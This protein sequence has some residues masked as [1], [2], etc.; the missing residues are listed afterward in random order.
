VSDDRSSGASARGRFIAFEGGEG[1]GK[2]TQ[3]ARLARSLDALLTREPGGTAVGSQLRDL[4]LDPGTVGLVAR[5][6][7]LLMAADRAQ[8]VEQVVGPALAAGRHVVT[9]RFAGSSV[10]YQGYGRGLAPDELLRLSQWACD[11]VWPDLVV[12]LDVD[13]D[14]AATRLARERDRFEREDAAFHRRIA[15][16]FRAMAEAD[17]GLWVVVDGARGEQ[18]VARQVR[19]VVAERLQLPV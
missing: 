18:D 9:D 4:L 5:A 6:E 10:A 16:G 7:A 11:G 17:P 2:S 14:V 15:D 12:L 8:H 19:E 3:A 13:P 1:S